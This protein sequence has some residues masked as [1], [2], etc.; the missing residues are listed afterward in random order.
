[1]S[2]QSGSREWILDP[3]AWLDL[4][5]ALVEKDGLT[6]V[7]SYVVGVTSRAIAAAVLT[8]L[9]KASFFFLARVLT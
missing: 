4:G 8:S 5:N 1:M 2:E 6:A 3:T 9:L 7:F